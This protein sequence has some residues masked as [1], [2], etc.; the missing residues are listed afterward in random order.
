M[1]QAYIEYD[2]G[3]E[4]RNTTIGGGQIKDRERSQITTKNKNHLFYLGVVLLLAIGIL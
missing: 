1:K 2:E 4:D 3:H